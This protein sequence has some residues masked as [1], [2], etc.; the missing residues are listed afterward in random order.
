MCQAW[1]STN[2]VLVLVPGIRGAEGWEFTRGEEEGQAPSLEATSAQ[3]GIVLKQAQYK[4]ALSWGRTLEG[5]SGK[6]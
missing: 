6:R 5:L 3:E 4:S 2:E 1:H